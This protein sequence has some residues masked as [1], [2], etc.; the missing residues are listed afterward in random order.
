MRQVEQF[1][2]HH[3]LQAVNFRDPVTDLYDRAH[4]HYC[5]PGLIAF[6][7]LTDYFTDLICFNVFHHP[8]LDSS[9]LPVDKRLQETYN[10]SCYLRL[11]T[12]GSVARAIDRAGFESSRRRSRCRYE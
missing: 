4:F 9:E 12:R 7:L 3:L 8:S 11:T 5:D 10:S 1:A 2:G 6:D